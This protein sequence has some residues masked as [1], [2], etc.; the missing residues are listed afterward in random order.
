M[1]TVGVV[2]LAA[3]GPATARAIDSVIRQREP[4][5]DVA[6]VLP[7]VSDPRLASWLD[8][9]CGQRQWSLVRAPDSS[10]GQAINSGIEALR[11]DWVIALDAGDTL[12][13]SAAG[14]VLEAARHVADSVGAMSF[15]ARL[16]GLAFDELVHSGDPHSPAAFDPAHPAL[17]GLVW[18]RSAVLAAGGFDGNLSTALRYELWLRLLGRGAG[19][20]QNG[21]ALLDVSVEAGSPLVT[22]TSHP[23]LGAASAAIVDRHLGLLSAHV[24]AVLEARARRVSRLGSA[25]LTALE[26]HRAAEALLTAASA[27]PPAVHS[28]EPWRASPLSRDWGYERGGP[29][30]RHY[31]ERFLEQHAGDVRGAVLEVQ[32]AD[33]TRRY[34]GE[35]VT[36]SDVVD[37]VTANAAATVV[38]DLRRAPNIA[39]DTYDCVIL[40]QTL[41]VIPQM[42]EV[43]AECH[44]I[45]APGGVLLL[46]VPAVS[47]VCLEYGRD[48][49]FWRLTPAGARALV[50]PVFGTDLTVV[51]FGNAGAGAAF[52]AGA[53]RDELPEEVRAVTDLYHPTLVAVRAV[54]AGG[55]ARRAPALAPDR[56]TQGLALLYHRVGATDPDPHRINVPREAF[57]DQMSWLQAHCAVLPLD[58][59]VTGARR[60]TLPP[61]AVALTFDDGYEDTLMV[62]APVLK[63]LQLPATC[64][65][66][67][68]ALEGT[69]EFWWDTLA[70]ALL[71]DG[72]YPSTLAVQLPDAPRILPT[73][74]RGE[75][76]FAHGMVY[77]AVVGQPASTRSAVV[78]AVRA[79]AP[80]VVRGPAGRRMSAGD[81]ARL[82]D[83]GIAV[84]AHTVSHPQLPRLSLTDQIREIADC[85][86]TL[87]R[88][89]KAPV[90]SLAYPFGAFDDT[91]V[92]AARQAGIASAWTCEP[93]GIRRGD[94]PLALPR[95]DPQATDLRQF[96][97]RLEAAFA[98]LT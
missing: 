7:P 13:S 11:T 17:R 19:I 37:L 98:Q 22:E 39:S 29:V 20:E 62:A 32:E 40:T 89:V 68:E 59:L 92:A 88:V 96:T 33:Y 48:G 5:A 9:T 43:I 46:T 79:W 58:D 51:P 64:F 21:T 87:E 6:V 36:R 15:A 67:T 73:A 93:R 78:S 12:R 4:L 47:R 65:V 77:D 14:D 28:I 81:I 24:G 34:G 44:R 52:L 70:S 35:A 55:R 91:T 18:R 83:Y 75:R 57:A 56:Q 41:H 95:Y 25:H 63:A 27:S 1:T 61:R 82:A 38:A 54:K 50:E 26:R 72:T 45:L 94:G 49:D 85:R 23:D 16:V 2:V 80:A 84:G 30:D 74:T 3:D 97:S 60:G 53:G 90:T 42:A 66:A 71:G 31:I 86:A 8:A 69:H 76:L 10:P